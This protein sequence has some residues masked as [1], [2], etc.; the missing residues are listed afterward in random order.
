MLC[1]NL[2]TLF[3]CLANYSH[4]VTELVLSIDSKNAKKNNVN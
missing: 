1:F 4:V 3:V 2:L